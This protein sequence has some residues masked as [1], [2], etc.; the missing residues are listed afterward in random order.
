MRKIAASFICL[1]FVTSAFGQVFNTAETLKSGKISLGLNPAYYND[2][3]GFFAHG[4][5]GLLS[6][7][8]FSFKYG[9][10]DG[11]DYVGS[12]LEW[13]IKSRRP[14]LSLTTGAHYV[15][16]IGLDC[17]FNISTAI[18][19]SVHIY[20]GADS[21]IELA[22]NIDLL[23]WIPV[24]IDIRKKSKLSFI[25]EAEIPVISAAFPIID[26]GIV[27]YIN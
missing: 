21:D 20:S 9:I 22:D 25:L 7:I 1:L 18:V 6:G 2:N 26:G 24:G 27:F 8:D 11:S 3:L 4:N 13:K 23:L 12:D 17:S 10:L 15:N 5:V 14:A 19:K 16:D